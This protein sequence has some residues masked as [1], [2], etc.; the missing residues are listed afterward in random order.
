MAGSIGE[1]SIVIEADA[2]GFGSDVS[3]KVG[4]AG[5]DAGSQF[6]DE[7]QRNTKSTAAGVAIG[8]A[9]LA[10]LQSVA[11]GI[12][13]IIGEAMNV[14][15]ATD[16]F[17]Q[18]LNFAGIDTSQIDKLTASTK[19]YADQTVY[20]LSDVQNVTAQLAANGVEGYDT[21]AMAAGNLNAVAGGNA[22][23]FKSVGMALTQTA[24]QGKLTTENWNQLADAIPGASGVLQDALLK[25]GAYTGNFR[26]AMAQ[27]Q[28]TA[29]EFNAAIQ[30]VGSDPIAQEAA[31]S[32]T[33][34]EGAMGN[35]NAS[36][37]S[38]ATTIVDVLKPAFTLIAS[39]LA[40]F[41]SNA[42]VAIPVIAGLGA[43][44]LAALA[45]AIWGAVTAT[46][47]FTA[48]LLANPITWV[49]IAIGA[50]VAA[51][52]L[53][54]MNWDTVVAFITDVWGGFVG[55]LT[56]ITQGIADWWNSL[57]ASVGQF[58]SDVWSGFVSWIQGVWDGFVSFIR[59]ALIAYVS[60]WIGIW[61]TVKSAFTSVWNGIVSWATSVIGA[62][63]AWFQSIWGS[64]TGFFAGLWSGITNGIRSAWNG[65]MSFLGGLPGQIMGFFSGIGQWLWSAGSDLIQGLLNG[66]QSA[67]GAVGDFLLGMIQDAV[68]GVMDFLQ[69][70]SP[71]KL[72]AGVGKDTMQGY[73]N[74]VDTLADDAQTALLG[75][76]PSLSAGTGA[77]PTPP[78]S[79]AA[80]GA[81]VA[82]GGRGGVTVEAGAFQIAGADPYR[83]SLAVVDRIAERAAFA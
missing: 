82:A 44:L 19:A 58:V 15:D 7:F 52:V 30:Q 26:D 40:A 66:I 60:M 39:G 45:P 3:R 63:V 28:I 43:I 42:Q 49:V 2:S 41:F 55:W 38:L 11:S 65:V 50:L 75:A 21:L 62:L 74:G 12:S 25:A 59:A 64:L 76:V 32:T 61:N 54:I 35:L 9:L 20:S 47:A 18:T 70:G 22:D 56:D 29:E 53:L 34:F 33:T 16:K 46:W 6:G 27:G 23:T 81:S 67:A 79:Q 36:V 72:M 4:A 78:G 68:G 51:I 17:K 5:R 71:S 13:D 31:T 48:A 10:G 83:V 77:T 73:I 80:Y 69:I 37:L 14:S 57:W 1:A 24:G 8:G